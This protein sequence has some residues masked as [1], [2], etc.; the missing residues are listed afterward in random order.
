MFHPLPP[1]E[2]IINTNL[3][4]LYVQMS[5]YG[6][7]DSSKNIFVH[8]LKCVHLCVVPSSDVLTL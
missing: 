3:N 2:K 6:I 7:S 8:I 4:F 5:Q 1:T